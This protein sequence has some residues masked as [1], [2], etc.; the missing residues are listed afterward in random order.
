MVGL[1]SSALD[2]LPVSSQGGVNLACFHRPRAPLQCFSQPS[3]STHL[4]QP[5]TGPVL[6]STKERRILASVGPDATASQHHHGRQGKYA[7]VLKVSEF[8]LHVYTSHD[9]VAE[10]YSSTTQGR[11]EQG[12]ASTSEFHLSR[13]WVAEGREL[14]ILPVTLVSDVWKVKPF[15]TT[16]APRRWFHGGD[17]AW[18]T[19]G[20]NLART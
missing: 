14:C 1:G 8:E 19:D 2:G 3:E 7:F 5:A 20:M 15:V 17:K 13:G 10:M 4:L 12:M 9:G 16:A 11:K 6:M 18:P